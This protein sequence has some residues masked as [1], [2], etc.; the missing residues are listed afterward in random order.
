MA[1][2]V[3]T[4]DSIESLVR[5][6][7]TGIYS[8][9]MMQPDGVWRMNHEGTFADFLSM[10]AGDNVYFFI[11]RKIYGIGILVDVEGDCKFSSFIG[12][13]SPNK[14]QNTEYH[15]LDPM[16]DYRTPENRCFCVFKPA[17]FF[18]SEGVDMDEALNSNPEKFRM[19]RALWKLS[20]VKID[21]EENRA[22]FDCILKRNEENLSDGTKS[23]EFR[24]Q[25][26]DLIQ[27]VELSRYRLS[28]YDLLLNASNE[29]KTIK[30]EMAIEAALCE[31][32]TQK[33]DTIFGSWDYVSHQVVASPF[34]PIDYM[35]KMD[36]FGY[37]YIP[38]YPTISRYLVIEI[39][40]DVAQDDVMGQIMKYVDWINSEY[41]HN[42]YSMIEAYIVAADFSEEAVVARNEICQRTYL[43]GLRPAVT[44]IWRNVKLIKY[45]FTDNELLLTEITQ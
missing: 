44:D 7:E 19:L 20:F 6:V 41:A 29:D 16:I 36:I 24:C 13:L 26:H 4:L 39:K 11:K 37:R 3:I 21:D 18:F 15:E 12:S 43:S 30:H 10:K 38:G 42:N 31:L 33:N 1:G 40:R 35:D 8:T 34:K 5:C 23:Y 17:P 32:L 28:A 27:T 22:L 25:Y 14:I 9:K 45:E 2:Y